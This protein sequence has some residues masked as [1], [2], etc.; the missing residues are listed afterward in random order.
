M[1]TDTHFICTVCNR[2]W[3][4]ETEGADIELTRCEKH[5]ETLTNQ[6]KFAMG[7]SPGKYDEMMLRQLK[8]RGQA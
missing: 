2:R 8:I 6:E 5:K 4:I 1:N 7:Y 3:G